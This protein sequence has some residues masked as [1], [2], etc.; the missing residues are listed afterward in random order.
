MTYRLVDSDKDPKKI[1]LVDDQGNITRGIYEFQEDTM[2]LCLQD[3]NTEERPTAFDSTPESK[4]TL[5]TLK[6]VPRLFTDYQ[7]IQGTYRQ[8]KA[9]YQ[10]YS[11]GPNMMDEGGRNDRQADDLAVSIDGR[12]NDTEL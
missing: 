2:R 10:L 3:P 4:T 1:N 6:V 11:V 7:L 9:G 5:L 12:I 8:T